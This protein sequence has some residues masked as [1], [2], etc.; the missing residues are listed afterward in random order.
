[1]KTAIVLVLIA[2]SAAWAVFL[3]A[4]RVDQETRPTYACYHADI[5]IG[6]AGPFGQPVYVAFEND[7][8]PF[9]IERSDIAFQRSTDAGQTWLENDV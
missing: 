4:V 3:P 2:A 5:A 6:P 8:V 9:L 1:M 7:S